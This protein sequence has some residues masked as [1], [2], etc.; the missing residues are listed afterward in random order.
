MYVP[1]PVRPEG[2][3]AAEQVGLEG[4][5]Q[6]GPRRS[7]HPSQGQRLKI[8]EVMSEFGQAA[9][10]GMETL[11]PVQSRVFHSAYHTNQN[12]L[13]CAPT[14]AGKTNVAL[15][16]VMHE[17][18]RHIDAAGV[19]QR[20][21]FKIVYIAPM[22]ALAAEVAGKFQERLRPLGITVKELTGDMQLTKVGSALYLSLSYTLTMRHHVIRGDISISSI[23]AYLVCSCFCFSSSRDVWIDT[24]G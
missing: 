3:S 14:G 21:L 24:T 8:K 1:P 12:L 10:R 7:A 11:N 19:L 16:A 6:E 2:L 20:D 9:F 23:D 17:I 22:K 18:E 5:A 15:L 4:R 13:V